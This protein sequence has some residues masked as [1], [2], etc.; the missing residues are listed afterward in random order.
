M[1]ILFINFMLILTLMQYSFTMEKELD[2]NLSANLD[3][4]IIFKSSNGKEF[5]VP[6]V[7]ASKSPMLNAALNID[8]NY[9][10]ESKYFSFNVSSE[11]I[12]V[13]LNILYGERKFQI[14]IK[15][16]KS[17]DVDKLCCIADYLLI[18][19]DIVIEKILDMIYVSPY[20]YMAG[21]T[22]EIKKRLE[23]E[24]SKLKNKEIAK[25]M[26]KDCFF[27]FGALPECFY[28]PLQNIPNNHQLFLDIGVDY[29]FSI[30]EF[31]RHNKLCSIDRSETFMLHEK[32]FVQAESV[33]D[34]CHLKYLELLPKGKYLILYS[35]KLRTLSGFNSIANLKQIVTLDLRNN[36]LEHLQ[37]KHL[38]Q[39][40][41]LNQLYLDSNRLTE[42]KSKTFSKLTNL[43]RLSLTKN[44]INH[45]EDGAFDSLVNL[46]SLSIDNNSLSDWSIS[47]RLCI[48]LKNLQVLR[49]NKNS[50]SNYKQKRIKKN[51]PRNA[52]VKIDL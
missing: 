18:D 28:S 4:N 27:K 49:L 29:G 10:E 43:T 21:L 13:L 15:E 11:I 50:L 47:D 2:I 33:Y 16:I 31:V 17:T 9:F 42:I 26:A 25:K 51:C 14:K 3:N 32:E 6:K 41:N 19:E 36:Q 5:L 12:K 46:R 1:Q 44:L 38:K 30:K 8:N 7:I 40:K 20:Y 39:L 22:P 45:I 24:I 52:V 23:K 48:N 37:E 34:Y 35:S